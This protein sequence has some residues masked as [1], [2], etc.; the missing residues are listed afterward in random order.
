MYAIS[1]AVK[2][3]T[4]N[5]GFHDVIEVDNGIRVEDVIKKHDWNPQNGIYKLVQLGRMYT[6]HKG[7]DLL[8][9]A[10]DILL[11]KGIKNFKMH[12]I[13]DG[14]SMEEMKKLSESLGLREFVVFEGRKTQKEV[15]RQLCGYDVFVQPSRLEGFG[16]TV[17][18]AMA[19]KLPVLVSNLPGPMEVIGNGLLGMS[20][21]TKNIEDL[22][23]KLEIVLKGGYDYSLIDK[24]YKRT[25]ELYDVRVTA[26]KY[27]DEYN[28]V[29]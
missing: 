21:E 29:L 5:Q 14:P 25:L 9:R 7:Q 12:F 2:E 13:G 18:E 1:N 24:A 4:I 15:Y 8:V 27:I 22:A 20:F 28:K 3:F 17:A 16:L 26:K 19:A 6:P 23:A 10:L 11:R